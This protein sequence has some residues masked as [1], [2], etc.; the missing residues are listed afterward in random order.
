MLA[1]SCAKPLLARTTDEEGTDGESAGEDEGG[2]HCDR[3]MNDYV[4]MGGWQVSL[5]V[6]PEDSV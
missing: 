2:H 6:A 3:Y 5:E 1:T 4:Q